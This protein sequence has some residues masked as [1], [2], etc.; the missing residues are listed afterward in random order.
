MSIAL[1]QRQVNNLD[2]EIADLE[3][4]KAA[5]DKESANLQE[6]INRIKK[7]ITKNTSLTTLNTK[8][9]EITR[10][11]N[12]YTK[13]TSDSA[14]LG[15]KIA[16]KRSSRAQVYLKLQKAQQTDQIKQQKENQLVQDA[17]E[18]RIDN[19]QKQIEESNIL[20][21]SSQNLEEEHEEYDVFISHAYEDK[22]S[23]VD[24]LFMEMEKEKLK[25]W[26]D[27]NQLFWGDSMREKIDKG[28]KKSRYGIVILSPNYIAENK[29]WT[30]AELDGLFQLESINGKMIL[31][32]WHELTKQQV[33]QYSPM[34]AS[35]MAM[36]TASMTP[37][38]I[39]K[40]LK[41]LF[42]TKEQNQ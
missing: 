8:S 42:N 34:I 31:P 15:K 17:Y 2:K 35:R 6:K 7:S 40:E 26:Y 11:S 9:R 41:K 14:K 12:D 21:I 27:T 28:L 38:E 32:I 1:Y 25:V 33:L 18:A 4:K 10:Y 29:Y 3:K 37:A 22:E 16:E 24:E 23:F 39:A 20:K 19:L 5:K 36:T 13:K 30:K